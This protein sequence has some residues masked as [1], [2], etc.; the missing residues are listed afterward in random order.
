MK[1]IALAFALVGLGALFQPTVADVNLN[2]FETRYSEGEAAVRPRRDYP[3]S[4]VQQAC[5]RA[6]TSPIRSDVRERLEDRLNLTLTRDIGFSDARINN[7]QSWNKNDWVHCSGTVKVTDWPLNLAGLAIR[8]AWHY[9]GGNERSEYLR[10]L[11]KVALKHPDTTADAV[12]LIAHLAP[13]EQQRSYLD[14]N[15]ESDKL[16]MPAAM[17]SVAEIWFEQ[18]RWAE[19]IRLTRRCDTLDCR[20]LRLDAEEQKE[21]EDAEKVDDLSSYF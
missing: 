11:L 2:Q 21:I 13:K 6:L 3:D 4:V 8:L 14:T 12:A 9:A 20:R 18:G 15:L 16:T 5:Q 10:P 7:Y 19:V 1:R 17:Q